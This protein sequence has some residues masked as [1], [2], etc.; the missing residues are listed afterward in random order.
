MTQPVAT[1]L[2]VL[3]P[4]RTQP[5][6]GDVCVLRVPGGSHLFGRVIST[7]AFAGPSMGGAVL[8]YIYSIQSEDQELPDRSALSPDRLLVPPMMT[9]RKPWT[10]GYFETVAH[11]RFESGDVLSQ[12]CFRRWDGR[13][14]DESLS[15]LPGAVEPVGDYGVHSFRT[16]D[17]A[18]SDGT[19]QA[20]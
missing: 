16:I 18:I 17:D 4:S 3:T 2:A 19:C 13:Y 6:A 20:V 14:F 10:L 12:H 8:I 1:N 9:N 11:L 7:E 5:Q 15:E